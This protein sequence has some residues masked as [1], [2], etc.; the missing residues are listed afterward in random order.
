MAR[1]FSFG[2]GSR[3]ELEDAE[4][5]APWTDCGETPQPRWPGGRFDPGFVGD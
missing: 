4:R 5:D 1:E 2:G 3:C